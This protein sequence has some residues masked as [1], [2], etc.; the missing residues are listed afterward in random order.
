MKNTFY[1]LSVIIITSCTTQNTNDVELILDSKSKLGEGAIWNHKTG[2]LLWID[3]EGEILNFYNPKLGNN[4]EM[5]TGQ[6]IGTVVPTN[7]D[8]VLVALEEGIYYLDPGTGTKSFIINPEENSEGFRFNDGK[9]DPKG[10]FWAGTMSTR[11][12]KEAGV[13]YRID[14]DSTV[15]KMIENVSISNGIVWSNDELAM[16][17]IDTPTQQVKKYDYNKE[18][19]E[20]NNPQTV[21]EIP[22]EMGAPDGMTIDEDGNL[23][24]ALWGGSA[25]GCWNPESGELIQEIEVPAKNVTSCA[26]GDDDLKTLYITTA[27]IGTS[28]EDLKRFPEAGGLFKTRLGVKGVKASFFGVEL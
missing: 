10:R 28:D 15:N 13:L 1:I 8:K 25:V 22:K 17:Y 6:R 26:F 27:R 18:T 16:F 20:I 23:W 19:G 12:E 3:I 9:C 4:R 2:E 14:P 21:I 5:F 7:S 11:G 24:I